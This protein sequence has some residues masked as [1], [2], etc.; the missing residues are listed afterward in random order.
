MV[1]KAD[2]KEGYGC[3]SKDMEGY[4]EIFNMIKKEH[5]LSHAKGW[6]KVHVP[7]AAKVTTGEA[8]VRKRGRKKK[9]QVHVRMDEED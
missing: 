5:K 2:K 9:K 1:L 7:T 3:I 4:N 8:T 6:L